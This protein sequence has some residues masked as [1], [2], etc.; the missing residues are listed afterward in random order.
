L[1]EIS[2]DWRS[3]LVIVKP[4]TVLT[5]HRKGFRVFRTWK[6]RHGQPGRPGVPKEVRQL[7]RQLCL[8]HGL[9]SVI[10]TPE[11]LVWMR[12]RWH[13]PELR[14]F[15]TNERNELIMMTLP[16]HR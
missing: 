8:F 2:T 5:R 6:I 3:A 10:T 11:N 14:R 12:S 9:F 7:I 4:Q 13:H 1:C 15:L 16:S